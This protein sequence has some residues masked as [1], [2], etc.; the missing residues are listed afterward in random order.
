M[1]SSIADS[2][3]VV[4]GLWITISTLSARAKGIWQIYAG[5]RG[6]RRSGNRS[7][8]AVFADADA[9]TGKPLDISFGPV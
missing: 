1:R 8:G 9:G 7:A 6:E 2:R 5:I 4:S 3:P